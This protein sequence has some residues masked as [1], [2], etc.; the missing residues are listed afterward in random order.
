MSG[1]NSCTAGAP[2]AGT[3]AG[4]SRVCVR[5]ARLRDDLERRRDSRRAEARQ[6]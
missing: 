6:L 1:S 5:R 2:P 3:L 4:P